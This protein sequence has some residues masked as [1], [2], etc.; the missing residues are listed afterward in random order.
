M[1]S[2]ETFE[3]CFRNF[4]IKTIMSLGDFIFQEEFDN[5]PSLFLKLLTSHK[6]PRN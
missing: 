2:V 1:T 3:N 6:N 4:D 5:S